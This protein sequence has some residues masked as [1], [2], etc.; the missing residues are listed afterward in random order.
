MVRIK[1]GLDERRFEQ[2]TKGREFS[3]DFLR[4]ILTGPKQ[5]QRFTLTELIGRAVTRSQKSG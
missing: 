4:R 1:E 3:G 2:S 5:I